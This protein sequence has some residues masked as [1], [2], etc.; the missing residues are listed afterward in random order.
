MAH[1]PDS[2]APYFVE[3]IRRYLE[4][5]YGSDQVH[6]GG[7]RVYTSLDM[8]LQRA[9]NRALLDGLA[10]YERR[11]GWRGRLQNVLTGDVTLATTSIRTGTPTPRSQLRSR[12]GDSREPASASV[13]FGR[14]SAT[15]TAADATWTRN[16]LSARF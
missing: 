9:A 12:P 6:E 3:E 2:L 4:G 15:L 8:D 10:A 11:H 13:R 16:K 5:K 7:L 14:Y 1:D